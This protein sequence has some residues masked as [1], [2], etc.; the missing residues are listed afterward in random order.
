MMTIARYR[1]AGARSFS[2]ASGV[3]TVGVIGLGLMGHGIAQAAAEKGYKVVAVELEERFLQGGLK[4]IGDSVKKI[5]SKAVE[6]GKMD[7]AA[8]D[9]HV[10]STM[11][12]LKAFLLE[13]ACL[14]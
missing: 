4:R 5:T 2:T 6:K 7:K 12:R 13:E 8:G 11:A 3:S 10:A 9:T 1:V 14:P